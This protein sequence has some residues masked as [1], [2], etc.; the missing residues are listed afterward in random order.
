MVVVE[1]YP[2]LKA[3][4]AFRDLQVAAGRNGEPDLRRA[5]ALHPGGAGVQHR[6]QHVPA[7]L[8]AGVFGSRFAEKSYFK[9]QAG[10]ETAPKVQF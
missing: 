6:A 5:H 3:T 1:H 10:A 7:E 4:Q 9:A 2:D 8:I